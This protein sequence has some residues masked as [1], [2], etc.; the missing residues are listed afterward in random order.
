LAGAKR[1]GKCSRQSTCSSYSADRGFQFSTWL[2]CTT[3]HHRA[4]TASAHTS[5]SSSGTSRFL[6]NVA[7]Y[8]HVL[9]PLCC[10]NP[11]LDDLCSK[12][13]RERQ[14]N[15]AAAKAIA[16]SAP[17]A[18]VATPQQLPPVV[19]AAMQLPAAVTA[20]AAVAVQP[21]PQ[22]Q[23]AQHPVA[24]VQMPVPTPAAAV[25]PAVSPVATPQPTQQPLLAK[26][27][28]PEA[29]GTLSAAAAAAAADSGGRQVQAAAPDE[30]ADEEPPRR[31]QKNT[32]RCFSCNKKV[33]TT[34]V[35]RHGWCLGD[36]DIW[37]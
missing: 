32:S 34:G 18:V 5:A 13:N 9:L 16:S 7:P 21:Q 27:Q 22:T 28:L 1:S 30:G 15:E 4:P 19:P 8:A 17:P 11:N 6:I 2:L 10:R 12:C 20:P 33:R 29:Q 14:A 24:P 37:L 31:V 25:E 3:G 35:T 23:P 26:L 36:I